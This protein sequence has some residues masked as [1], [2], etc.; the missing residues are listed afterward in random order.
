MWFVCWVNKF[1]K[2]IIFNWGRSCFATISRNVVVGRTITQFIELD[3]SC[4]VVLEFSGIWKLSANSF[5]WKS[6]SSHSL[7]LFHINCS[8]S[9]LRLKFPLH[10]S[11]WHYASSVHVKL[12]QLII[13]TSSRRS[14]VGWSFNSF[15]LEFDSIFTTFWVCVRYPLFDSISFLLILLEFRSLVAILMLENYA[16][17]LDTIISHNLCLD[18]VLEQVVAH[19][20]LR[21]VHHKLLLWIR[22]LLTLFIHVECRSLIFIRFHGGIVLISINWWLLSYDSFSLPLVGAIPFYFHVLMKVSFWRRFRLKIEWLNCV[23]SIV[24]LVLFVVGLH[25]HVV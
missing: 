13:I 3:A 25:R 20:L 12:K 7:G 24:P 5:E 10:R 14:V 22:R 15:S 11:K 4:V 6:I 8:G 1:R 23:I 18:D 21:I 17:L 19:E 2:I 9:T 16:S